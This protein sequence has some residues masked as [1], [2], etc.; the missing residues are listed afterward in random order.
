MANNWFISLTPAP[1][2][3]NLQVNALDTITFVN[4]S[5][6][7]VTLSNLPGG[8]S[9]K[10]ATSQA[11]PVGSGTTQYKV[12][13]S[14]VGGSY[15]W[16]Q[17]ATAGKGTISVII[18]SPQLSEVTIVGGGASIDPV[19]TKPGN[20]IRWTNGNLFPINITLPQCVSPGD[21]ATIALPAGQQSQIYTINAQA[22]SNSYSWTPTAKVPIVAVGQGTIDVS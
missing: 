13:A 8:L 20:K 15:D 6:R 18:P 22:S 9:P 17:G 16:A 1:L 2:P 11:I 19:P 5:A 14:S 4:P 7:G 12:N 3:L 21:Q 10:P